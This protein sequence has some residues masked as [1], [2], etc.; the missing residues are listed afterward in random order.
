M[1]GGDENAAAV[2][3][4][5]T[6]GTAR[7]FEDLGDAVVTEFPLPNGRRA[8]VVALGDDSTLTLVE[9]KS[10]VPDFRADAKWPDYLDF[11]DRFYFAVDPGFPRDRLPDD[12]V[13]GVIVTD[14]FEAAVVREAPT[15]RL[16]AAR[17]KAVIRRFARVAA[18]RLR[19]L[20]DPR[21]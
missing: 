15:R 11:C 14:A 21:L 4:R 20:T 16:S 5:L 18:R 17:R 10:G 19:A 1:S 9:V 7:M 3:D 12:T 2:T 13:C 6:R 8:D